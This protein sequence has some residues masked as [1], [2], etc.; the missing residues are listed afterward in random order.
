MIAAGLTPSQDLMLA[1]WYALTGMHALHVLGGAIVNVWH[2]ATAD[3]V[4][5]A[6][7]ERWR[8]RI[9]ATRLYWLFVDLIWIAILVAFYVG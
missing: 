9:R 3:A 2:A 4:A 8:E 1:S 5:A 6:D 7:P